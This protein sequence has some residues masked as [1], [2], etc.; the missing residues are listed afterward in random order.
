M[1]ALPHSCTHPARLLARLGAVQDLILHALLA[2]L[3]VRHPMPPRLALATLQ[4]PHAAYSTA[5][6]STAQY[7]TATSSCY[8]TPHMFDIDVATRFWIKQK[9]VQI[10]SLMDQLHQRC[11]QDSGGGGGGGSGSGGGGGGGGGGGAGMNTGIAV[12]SPLASYGMQ[13]DNNIAASLQDV[14]VELPRD[15]G[16]DERH[17]DGGSANGGPGRRDRHGRAGDAQG[18]G[19][20]GAKGGGEPVRSPGKGRTSAK[21]SSKASG[22]RSG[23]QGG[24]GGKSPVGG[25]KELSDDVSSH[26]WVIS[27]PRVS[28]CPR[29]LV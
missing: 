14:S 10:R 6:Y 8:T 20:A 4:P 25:R 18:R 2:P 7:S 28:P 27:S 13:A 1:S 22:G 21:A 19:K 17:D 29:S 9:D 26:T 5:Q 16:Y 15:R 11:Q 3:P 24:H 23:R 12:S